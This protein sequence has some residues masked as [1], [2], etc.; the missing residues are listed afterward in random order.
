MNVRY[1]FLSAVCGFGAIAATGAEPQPATKTVP[2]LPEVLVESDHF[3]EVR[4][5]L[6]KTPGGVGL[7]TAPQIEATRAANLKDVFQLTPGVY[8]QP[9]QGSADEATLSIRGSGIRNAFHLRGIRLYLDGML[10]SNAD[11][12][13][14]FD[15]V[16][17]LALD[18]IEVYKGA[19]GLAFGSSALGGGINFVSKT[20]YNSK[21]ATIRAEAGSFGFVKGQVSTGQRFSNG[22]DYYASGTAQREDGYRRHQDLERERFYGN[23]GWKLFQDT[24]LRFY[25]M[26]MNARDELAGDLTKSQLQLAPQSAVAANL[27][28]NQRRDSEALRPALSAVH[29]FDP[30]QR[31]ELNLYWQWRDLDHP[32]AF[33]FIDNEF[34]DTG[35]EARYINTTQVADRASEF[36]FGVTPQYGRILD[37]N[38]AN[39]L[40]S[41][42]A[43]TK[44]Q[45]NETFNMGAWVQESY[46][47]L[48]DWKAVAGTRFDWSSRVLTDR[49]LANGNQSGE[50]N[51]T[52]FS[53]RLGL[54]YEFTSDIQAFG[55]LS[56]ANEP[57]TFSEQAL[58][59]TSGLVNLEA[60]KSYQ[61]EIGTRGKWERMDWDLSLYNAEIEDEL[62]QSTLGG[63]V[64]LLTSIPR[65][66]HTGV[67]VGVGFKVLEGI[68]EQDSLVKKRD[69][70]KVTTSYTWSDFR[71][72]R[73][74]PYTGK[75]LP[76]MPENYWVT[77][78]SYHHPLGFYYAFTVEMAPTPYFVDKANNL[79]ND[80][81]TVFGMK[82]GM[83]FSNRLKIFAELRN[84][85]DVTYASAVSTIEIATPVSAQF[86]P[87]DGFALYS[88]VEWAY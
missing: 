86:K 58:S 56:G 82:A 50:L 7:V 4:Q 67:E 35:M 2:R 54:I 9:R 74:G 6:W 85:S 46:S 41:R 76:G 29:R 62:F 26:Y 24:E 15:A 37:A 88:G 42:G 49:F 64:S 52:G 47:F 51:Y 12:F 75:R 61:M 63:G 21:T 38:Y 5:E 43:L 78:L 18:H 83:E 8:S 16:E 14:D 36:I 20:G 59:G 81:Y 19:N 1:I 53:P 69:Y 79:Q 40:G 27:A 23:L 66:R 68:L 80:G 71:V 57:P 11:G 32:L 72:V 73:D 3:H 10:L 55:N 17:L 22:V 77:E 65:T 34:N 87:A 48:E 13:S 45:V 25:M 39:V 60:Q 44:L 28:L 31:L 84:L 33:A 30:D 70:L